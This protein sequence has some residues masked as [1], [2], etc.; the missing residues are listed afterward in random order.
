LNN[1]GLATSTVTHCAR[2]VARKSAMEVG[3]NMRSF[4]L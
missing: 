3:E 4:S 2:E 1:A